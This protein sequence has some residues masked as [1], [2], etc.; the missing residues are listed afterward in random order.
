MLK[1]MARIDALYLDGLSSS[2]HRMLE[3]LAKEGVVVSRY[4][5]LFLMRS[6][7]FQAIYQKPRT[8]VPADPSER[9]PYLADL[10]KV[11]GAEKVWASVV[12]TFH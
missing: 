4:Q 6:I 9:F 3:Y 12:T 5:T 11:R 8:T 2:N 10:K 7:G 1:I